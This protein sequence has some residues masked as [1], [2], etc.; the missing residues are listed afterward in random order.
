[1]DQFQRW[2][3]GTPSGSIVK[4]LAGTVLAFVAASLPEWQRGSTAPAVVFVVVQALVPVLINYVNAGD[5]RYGRGKART[6]HE[7]HD[8]LGEDD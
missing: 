4:V 5:P 2:L 6:L 7:P 8:V 3:A 1:M